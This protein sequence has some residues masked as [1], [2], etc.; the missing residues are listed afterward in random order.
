MLD[1]VPSNVPTVLF[2]SSSRSFLLVKECQQFSKHFQIF[3]FSLFFFSTFDNSH[4]PQLFLSLFS[5]FLCGCPYLNVPPLRNRFWRAGS[6]HSNSTALQFGFSFRGYLFRVA[7][8]NDSKARARISRRK[9]GPCKKNQTLP[10]IVVQHW[11]LSSV[12]SPP[13]FLRYLFGELSL[14]LL[15][16]FSSSGTKR[17]VVGHLLISLV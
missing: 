2:I 6:G 9:K 14:S 3:C 5:F 1:I 17:N 11:L 7:F 15:W 12:C 8:R 13:L 10:Y 16:R 4:H